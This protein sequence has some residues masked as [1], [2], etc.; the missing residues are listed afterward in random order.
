MAVKPR[1]YS[2]SNS[3]KSGYP[4]KVMSRFTLHVTHIDRSRVF[5]LELFRLASVVLLL[6]DVVF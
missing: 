4:I 5:G 1:G 6:R 3:L 2:G